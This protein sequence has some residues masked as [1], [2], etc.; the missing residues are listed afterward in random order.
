[1]SD[2]GVAAFHQQLNQAKYHEMYT[3]T[4]PE[5]QQA[6]S[7]K[8]ITELFNAIHT[9]LGDATATNRTGIFVNA[10][11]S[12]NF[13]RVNYQMTF[14]RGSAEE[15]FNWRMSNGQLTLVGYNIQSH[16]LMVK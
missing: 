12:G 2:A 9:K 14:A 15:T 1:M 8:E 6:T 11:T 4:S 16:D 10:T 5:F 7:E 3:N 13:A